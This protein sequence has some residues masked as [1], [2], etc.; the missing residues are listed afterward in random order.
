[1]DDKWTHSLESFLTK[2]NHKLLDYEDCAK[3]SVPDEDKLKWFKTSIRSH[4]I[5]QQVQTHVRTTEN[6]LAKLTGGSNYVMKFSDYYDLVLDAAQNA[7]KQWK[8][9]K[10]NVNQQKVK[11]KGDKKKDKT[12]DKSKKEDKKKD[13]GNKFYTQESQV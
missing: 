12:Q 1:M 7:D 13:Q 8:E 3:T 2:W 6:T 5:F 11:D 4:S 9:S 10:R